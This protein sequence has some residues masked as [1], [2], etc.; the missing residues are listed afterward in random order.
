MPQRVEL[1]EQ[2]DR[3][4]IDLG[5]VPI[6]K[7]PGQSRWQDGDMLQ[8]EKHHRA[9]EGQLYRADSEP[10]AQWSPPPQQR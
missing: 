4:D 7:Q 3:V 10:R 5:P 8:V 9:G 6:I 1:A 2:R